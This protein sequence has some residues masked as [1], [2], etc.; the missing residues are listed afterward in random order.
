MKLDEDDKKLLNI[1]QRGDLCIPR[2]TKIAHLLHLP[3]TTVHAKLKRLEREKVIKAYKPIID[4]KSVGFGLTV[5]S[6]IKARYEEIY[7][8]KKT[9]EDF[10]KKLASIPQIQE[11]YSCSGDWDFLIKLKVNSYE[12]YGEIATNKILPLGGIQRLESYVV[13]LT[14]KETSEIKV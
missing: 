4:A 3:T 14:H 11:V 6:L 12:E 9:I 10:G 5:F 2:T 13:A 1:I 7:K 8:D